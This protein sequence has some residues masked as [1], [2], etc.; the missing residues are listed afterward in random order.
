M[1]TWAEVRFSG[2]RAQGDGAPSFII[3]CQLTPDT[4]FFPSFILIKFVFNRVNLVAKLQPRQKK[5]EGI[6]AQFQSE[7]ELSPAATAEPCRRRR[8][9]CDSRTNTTSQKLPPKDFA[10]RSH[11]AR[12]LQ[13]R[14]E[15]HTHARPDVHVPGP[16]HSSEDDDWLSLFLSVLWSGSTPALPFL[17][18][19]L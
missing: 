8:T 18:S 3:G 14:R 11:D 13:T 10:P 4:I 19:A 12:Q 2:G 7:G 15:N 5:R 6:P 1:P 9:T 16:L 17:R